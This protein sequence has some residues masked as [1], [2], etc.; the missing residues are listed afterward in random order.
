MQKTKDTQPVAMIS[1]ITRQDGGQVGEISTA[2]GIPYYWTL[3]S[4]ATDIFSLLL[5]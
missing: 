1:G 2:K 5:Q 3:P 4:E